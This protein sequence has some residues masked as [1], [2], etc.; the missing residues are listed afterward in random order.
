VVDTVAGNQYDLRTG[1]V[2]EPTA[3]GSDLPVPVER[4]V[5]VDTDR[6][7][8]GMGYGVHVR[9]ADLELIGGVGFGG[10][11]RLAIDDTEPYYLEVETPVKTYLRVDA[12]FRIVRTST[13]LRV[14]FDRPESVVVAARSRRSAPAHELTV[15]AD[16]HDLL[17]ALSLFGTAVQ[18]TSP[19][20][21]YP[22]LRGH[23][24]AI[25]LG[26][27]FD[28]SADLAPPD[29]DVVIE[30]PPRLETAV[31][32]A[33]LAYY[34]GA[35][36]EPGDAFVVRADGEAVHNP[37]ASD[38]DGVATA[39]RRTLERVFVLECAVR[40]A[41]LYTYDIEPTQELRPLLRDH[42]GVEVDT[43]YDWSPARRVAAAF[44]LPY[45]P[46]AAQA[47]TWPHVGYVEPVPAHLPALPSLVSTLAPI[48]TADPPRVEGEPARGR[49]AALTARV[50]R[51]AGH[52]RSVSQVV[53]GEARYADL[54]GVDLNGGVATDAHRRLWV[55]EDI[56][57]GANQHL[58]QA[59]RNRQ[60]CEIGGNEPPIEVVVVSNEAAMDA[61]P[62]EIAATYERADVPFDVTVHRRL[63]RR[64]LRAVLGS[65]V[66]FF[67]YVG[68]AS[69]DGL[70][71]PDGHLDAASLAETGVTAF[72]LNAC[73][74]YTQ[75]RRLIAA[76]A[77]GGIVTHGQVLSTEAHE[78][79][80]TLSRLLNNGY[81]LAAAVD[82]AG[83]VHPVGSQYAVIGETGTS[84]C[85]PASAYT[86]LWRPTVTS[87]GFDLTIETYSV[88]AEQ[89]EVGAFTQWNVAASEDPVLVPGR[90]GPFD[91]TAEEVRD[92]LTANVPPPVLVGP[93][94]YWRGDARRELLDE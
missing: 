44:E 28:A 45:E 36:V 39:A 6:L 1:S 2:P 59:A 93:D 48:R 22:T 13:E 84:V 47:P 24:P 94:L 54:S 85:Q 46:L 66:D 86:E 37:G 88:P 77:L 58:L 76:G 57:L 81:S 70:R 73:Q 8:F 27:A 12:P 87:D 30:T 78:I 68:H 7:A 56:P 55:G 71:C 15:G 74:S 9:D 25:T 89:F 33:P 40:T 67:H 53:S 42:F 62:D 32:V 10:D 14:T 64:A 11:D 43:V 31:P 52:T 41:G 34:L 72:C 49:I 63:S 21:S 83:H 16:P 5:E 18:T 91:V 69:P 90:H 92:V 51:E 60:R 20:R 35:T 29:T 38:A 19:E 82:V 50:R 3:V 4:A 17:A 79:G 61:E 26:D 75:G 23:P 80:A 65:D